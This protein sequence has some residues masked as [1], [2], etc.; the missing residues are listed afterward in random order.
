MYQMYIDEPTVSFRRKI[1]SRKLILLLGCT[2][3]KCEGTSRYIWY[4]GIEVCDG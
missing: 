4:I 1:V 2:F 3:A